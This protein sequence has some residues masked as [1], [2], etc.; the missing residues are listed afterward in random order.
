[1]QVKLVYD[2]ENTLVSDLHY[3]FLFLQNYY[4]KIVFFNE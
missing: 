3:Q 1:M 4:Y 2:V